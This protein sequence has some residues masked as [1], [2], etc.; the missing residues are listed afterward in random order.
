[1]LTELWVGYETLAYTATRAWSPEAMAAAVEGLHG[2]GLLQGEQ[3]SE[4]GR[5][6]REQ[7]ERDTD[8]AMSAV[9]D[10]VGDDLG[11]V[12]TRLVGW[13]EQLIAAGSFPPDL[14]KRAAG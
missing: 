8:R 9:L 11:D 1:M 3:L 12:V 2:R 10:A 14:Y 5:A 7:V 13:G 4:Q 6:L